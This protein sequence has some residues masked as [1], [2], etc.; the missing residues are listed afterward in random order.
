MSKQQIDKIYRTIGKRITDARS[1]QNMSQERLAAESGIDRSHMGFIEQG[2][3][4]PTISTLYKIGQAL[5][6]KLED[7]FRG[8]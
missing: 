2:R 8:L 1:K 5:G 4:K 3:R 6:I 7:F